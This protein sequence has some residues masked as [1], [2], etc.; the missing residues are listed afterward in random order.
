MS[1]VIFTARKWNAQCHNSWLMWICEIPLLQIISY[2]NNKQVT[3]LLLLTIAVMI[4][5]NAFQ[6]HHCHPYQE[7]LIRM[8]VLRWHLYSF[9]I[10]GYHT[11]QYLE[12]KY[13]VTRPQ[14]GRV[15][16]SIFQ[17]KEFISLSKHDNI[18]IR[19]DWDLARYFIDTFFVTLCLM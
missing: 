1:N 6:C 5:W 14:M 10:I 16:K 19:P 18:S 11:F 17:Y 9:I 13:L 8:F 12:S 4:L 15:T 7:S 2:H 3:F